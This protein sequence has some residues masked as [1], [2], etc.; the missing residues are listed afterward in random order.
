M[1]KTLF[2]DFN[3]VFAFGTFIIYYTQNKHLAKSRLI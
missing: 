2:L 3:P 1:A